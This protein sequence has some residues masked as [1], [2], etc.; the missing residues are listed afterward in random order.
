MWDD[1]IV[2]LPAD[3]GNATVVM[4]RSEYEGKLEAM[5]SNGTYRKQK[6]DPTP[7]IER[8][9]GKTMRATEEK[10]ELTKEKQLVLTPR[11][12]APPQLYGLPKVHKSP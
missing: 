8:E 7:K 1:S 11:S 12:S 5:L 2:I 10:G 4:D 9:I 3:K 6:K